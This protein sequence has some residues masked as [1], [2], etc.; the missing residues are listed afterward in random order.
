MVEAI[1]EVFVVWDETRSSDKPFDMVLGFNQMT[2]RI[3]VKTLFGFGLTD[4]EINEVAEAMGFA[5]DYVL[6][7]MMTAGVPDWVPVPGRAR[8][9]QS[10]ET[11]DKVVYRIID[12]SR[13]KKQTDNH[14]LAMLLN[15]VDEETNEG[16]TD[17]QLHDEIATFFLAGYETNAIAL[18]WAVEYLTYHPETL[19]KLRTEVD[20]VLGD[21]R[22]TFADLPNLP[23]A[24]MAIQES[25]R[26]QPP[27]AWMSRIAITDDEIDGYP[28]PAGSMVF[29][30]IY[31]YH[32]HPDF[33][34]EPD[35]FRPE[36]FMPEEAAD[37][38]NFA[39]LPFSAGQRICIGRDFSLMEG[40]LG[41]AMLVQRYEIE[42][43]SKSISRPKHSAS[44]RPRDG[45][46]MYFKTR[47]K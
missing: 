29:L 21:R 19:E 25:M 45:V 47:S 17:Q 39:W 26:V 34:L 6:T 35:K 37:R 2:M 27:A 22:P 42:R 30:M 11:F 38:H 8:F 36:R 24:R 13:G 10:Q 1:E 33:W 31:M 46:N 16:M 18:S 9:H 15:A 3:I 23:Y 40:Q 44:L 12:E 5:L 43:A 14:L 7:A 4:D 20:S 32:R 41:L 28:I